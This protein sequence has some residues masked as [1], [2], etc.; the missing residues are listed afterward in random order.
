MATGTTTTA[1]IVAIVAMATMIEAQPKPNS[2]TQI[3]L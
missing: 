2:G 1:G 3:G